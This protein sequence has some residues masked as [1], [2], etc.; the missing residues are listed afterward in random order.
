VSELAREHGLGAGTSLERLLDGLAAEADPPTTARSPQQAV[1]VHLADSLAGLCVGA[2]GRARRVADLGAGAGFPG[3]ALAA[4]LPEASVD[5]IEARRRSCEVIERLARYAELGN[6]RAINRRAEDWAR[7]NGGE[8]YD[9]VT[10]RAVGALA[11]LYEYAAPLLR[12]GGTLIAWKGV[13]LAD[14][15]RAGERAAEVLGLEPVEVRPVQPFPGAH[16]RHLHVARKARATPARFPRR[17][18]VAE[19][20]P[21]A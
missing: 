5:L 8:E 15:E 10:V 16:S 7:D 21:L 9:V 3:L 2:L 1:D 19:K 6:A 20:R 14:E 17:A 13:R 11:L 4:A 18:G 12:V